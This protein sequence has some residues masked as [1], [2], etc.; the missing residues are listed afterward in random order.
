MK[1][2]LNR[3]IADSSLAWNNTLTNQKEKFVVELSPEIIDDLIKKRDN[4]TNLNEND[5]PLLTN[6]ILEFKKKMLLDGIGLFITI[7]FSM[8]AMTQLYLRLNKNSF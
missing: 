1:K 6:N 7:P 3:I 4:L 2:T 5:L 8:I